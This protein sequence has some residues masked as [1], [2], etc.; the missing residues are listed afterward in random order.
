MALQKPLVIDGGQMRNITA[1]DSFNHCNFPTWD[2]NAN[3]WAQTKKAFC[4]WTARALAQ[5]NQT[6][7]IFGNLIGSSKWWGGVL[8]SNGCIYGIPSHSTTIL[9]IG[10]NYNDVQPDFCL[11]RYDNKF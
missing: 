6:N 8:A 1:S 9:K 4:S 2:E 11:S 5:T 3:N 7:K 10:S